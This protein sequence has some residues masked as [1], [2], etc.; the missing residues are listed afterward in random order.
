MSNNNN[1]S[2]NLDQEGNNLEKSNL[3]KPKENI[4][5]KGWNDFVSTVTKGFNNFQ[6]VFIEQSKTHD[7][8]WDENKEKISKFFSD[9]KSNWDNMVGEWN[10]ELKNW[11]VENKELWD[12]NKENVNTFLKKSKDDWDNR[13]HQWTIDLQQKQSETKQQWEA[14]TRKIN[15]DF[16]KWQENT[17]KDWEKGLKS[18]RRE[19]IKGSYLFLV[20]M[21][22]I[23]VVFIVIVWLI[24][25]LLSSLSG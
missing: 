7:E 15:E 13:F 12:K 6:K 10:S 11:Q 3:E 21:I 23:L 9:A 2:E 18:W 16:K 20:F 24:N 19:M 4:F 8:L 14:R 5:Q 25:W 22:P 17:K 1:N